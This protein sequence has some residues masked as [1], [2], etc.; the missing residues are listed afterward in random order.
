MQDDQKVIEKIL[1]GTEQLMRT[2]KKITPVNIKLSLN[3]CKN[4]SN[5]ELDN[6]TKTARDFF[7]FVSLSGTSLSCVIL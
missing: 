6:L 5:N 4:L 1:V 2:D 3:A 7:Y